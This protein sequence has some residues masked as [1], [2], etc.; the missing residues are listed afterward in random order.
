MNRE[1]IDANVEE[2]IVTAMIISKEF[3]SQ[4]FGAF[5]AKLIQSKHLQIIARWC[6]KYFGKYRESPK[7]NIESIYNAWVQNGKAN[8]SMM[9]SVYEILE[10]LSDEYNQEPELNV[11]YLLDVTAE[12]FAKRKIEILRD[13]LEFSLSQ[14]DIKEADAA[15]SSHF[16]VTLNLGVGDDPLSDYETWDMAFAESQKPLIRWGDRSADYFFAHSL[17][18][19]SLVGM[20]APEKRGKTWWCVEF[21]VR[22]AEQRRKVALFEVGDMSKTQIWRRLGVRFSRQPMFRRDLGIVRVPKK[23]RRR[24]DQVLIKR[25]NI[26]CNKTASPKSCKKAVRKFVRRAGIKPGSTYL[27]T[28]VHPNSSINVA[29]VSSIL[30]RWKLQKGFIP[31]VVIIDY[32]DI[33]APEYG[34]SNMTTR[35]QINATWKALRR[36]SQ[37]WHCLV[38]APTQAPSASYHVETLDAT[39]FGE[40]KRKLSHVTGMFGLNQTQEEKRRGI[41]RLNWIVLRESDFSNDVCLTV[42]QCFT[43]GR[44]FC[45]AT[46]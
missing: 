18:R 41:M 33:L 6:L 5:D 17:A 9:D 26:E 30:E 31:D 46:L 22:A 4:V 19:D 40:D 43:L 37:E 10:K 45:C 3:L 16:A 25:I 44:A 27:M 29:E 15:I 12:H 11:P 32:P 7:A 13:Q 20:L 21:A 35:D 24:R 23:I 28:S 38:L 36:L 14:G 1:R 34:T 8:E 39:H 2:K 42:G